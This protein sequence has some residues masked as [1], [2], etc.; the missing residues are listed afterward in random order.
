[1]LIDYDS[2]SNIGGW[3]WTASIGTDA[4]PYFR[5]FNPTTQSQKFDPEGKF[6]RKYVKELNDIPKEYIH[7][8]YRYMKQLNKQYGIDIEKLYNKPIINHKIQRLRAT[9]MFNI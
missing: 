1:M 9:E 3:Q 5:N 8:L 4:V 2:A 7:E 6:I